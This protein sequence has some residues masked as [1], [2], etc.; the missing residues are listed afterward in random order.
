MIHRA[1]HP[2]AATA[3]AA[4]L[5][6]AG[7]TAGFLPARAASA[8]PASSGPVK[9]RAVPQFDAVAA[10]GRLVVAVEIDLGEKFH[11]WPAKAVPLA[12]DVDDFAIRTEVGVPKGEDNK[13]KLLPPFLAK[14]DGVQYPEAKVGKVA[15]PTGDKPTIEVPLYSHKAIAYARFTIAADAALGEQKFDITLSYQ[16]CDEKM[17]L[18]PEDLT[19][20]VKVRVLATGAAEKPN[21]NEA[22]LFEKFDAGKWG[23][24]DAKPGPQATPPATKPE[25]P[26]KTPPP[27]APAKPTAAATTTGPG[28]ASLFGISL[29]GNIFVLALAAALG[30]L[31]LNLTPC[32][33]PVIPIK[34]LTLTQHASSKSHALSL[35]LWMAFGV[36]AFWGVIGIPMAFISAG[37]DPS[38]FIFGIWWVTLGL[39]LV[40]ALMGLGIMGLFSINLPQSVYAVEAKAD[41]PLGSFLFGVLTGVLGLPCF[42]FVAAGLLAAAA[43]LPAVAIMTIFLGL[44]VGMAS[45]YLVLSIY[46]NL[47]RFIPRTGPASELVK[48]VM[49]L[50]LLAAAA[51]FVTAGIKALLTE[52]P[53]VA[54]S[55]TWWAVGFFVALAGIWMIVRTL[56]ISRSI[57]PRLVVPAVAV[58]MVLGIGVFAQGRLESDREAF[59]ERRV[60][61]GGAGVAPG[62]MPAGVWLEY[63]PELLAAVRASG[64][65]VFLDFTADWCITCKALKAAILDR[66]PVKAAFK[67]RGVVL[68]EVDC[69]VRKGGGSKFLN[70]LGRTGVPQWIVYGPGAELP[71]FIPIETP[72]SATVL[73]ELDA[74]GVPTTATVA[75]SAL[76]ARTPH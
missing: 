3:L 17:C 22:A 27:T 50:L 67:Q 20:P 76:P 7:I 26:P 36:V 48:Q 70:D 29:G 47:L 35:G 39:G 2:V 43:T 64:R 16:A 60:A 66:D 38:Q 46:P 13:P 8:Q 59:L 18:P 56:Q 42:G 65:P 74:A 32:V 30:G 34:V 68:M 57:G 62:Q 69:T 1:L 6:L 5:A 12:K 25:S 49:G 31:A 15:D 21:A 28:S 24:G 54:G 51:F 53:Y 33:L 71:R 44:G 40:I 19:I 72:T 73:S 75:G 58:V 11:A 14:F 37:L 55:M 23:G 9:V 4:V 61:M 52:R 41:S 10:G 63:T 45:P